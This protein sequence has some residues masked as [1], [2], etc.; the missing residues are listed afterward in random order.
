MLRRYKRGESAAIHDRR[1]F[2]E[3]SEGSDR[4]KKRHNDK[5][6]RFALKGG[7]AGGAGGDYKLVFE[8]DEVAA[9]PG[10]RP[11]QAEAFARAQRSGAPKPCIDSTSLFLLLRLRLLL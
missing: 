10:A 7:A 2:G 6:D 9:R 11:S 5:P 3:Y 1:G 8:A 4:Q